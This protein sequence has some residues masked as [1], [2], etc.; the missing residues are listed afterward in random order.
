M[1]EEA[2]DAE[3]VKAQEVLR[4]LQ[5][6]L[7]ISNTVTSERYDIVYCIMAQLVVEARRHGEL[8]GSRLECALG[9]LENFES[10]TR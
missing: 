8:K 2:W 9:L 10:A 3:T 1:V 5:L 4:D 6:R 7:P